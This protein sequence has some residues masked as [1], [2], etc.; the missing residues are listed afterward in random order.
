MRTPM[1][2]TNDTPL[3]ANAA[4]APHAAITMPARKGPSARAALNWALLSVTALRRTSRGT[5]SVTNDCQIGVFTPPASPD[6]NASAD[7]EAMVAD[8]DATSAHSANAQAAWP[9]CA[10]ISSVRRGY[11]SASVPPTRPI[12]MNGTYWKN[13]VMPTS[14]ALPVSV[15]AT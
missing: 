9:T 6:R 1:T 15:K 14:P 2:T 10:A 3:M 12:T 8:P 5:S 11:R 4:A 7:S 13:P